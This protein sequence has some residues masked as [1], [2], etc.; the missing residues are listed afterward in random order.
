MRER[1]RGPMMKRNGLA[2]KLLAAMSNEDAWW[3]LSP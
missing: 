1:E 2:C 3:R